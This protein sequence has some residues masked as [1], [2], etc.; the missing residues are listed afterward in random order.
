MK[1]CEICGRT[2]TKSFD[3]SWYVYDPCY[4]PCE[5][6]G[7]ING[8]S[9]V[10]YCGEAVSARRIADWERESRCPAHPGYPATQL[11]DFDPFDDSTPQE[12]LVL[13]SVLAASLRCRKLTL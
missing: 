5:C 8:V 6:C 1:I 2:Y 10:C 7:G 12:F 13:D 3:T 11:P 9:D 4:R